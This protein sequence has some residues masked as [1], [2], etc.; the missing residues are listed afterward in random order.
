L[1]FVVI[2]ITRIIKEKSH[3][4]KINTFMSSFKVG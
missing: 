1:F 4:S 3:G 2:Q